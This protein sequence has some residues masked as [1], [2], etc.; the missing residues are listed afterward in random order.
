MVF[1]KEAKTI[2]Q[3][4]TGFSIHDAGR[5]EYHMLKNEIRWIPGT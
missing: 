4:R 5:T 1:K 3:G 2:R